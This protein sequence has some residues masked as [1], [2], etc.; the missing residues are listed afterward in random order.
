MET[1]MDNEQKPKPRKG[2]V[3]GGRAPGQRN[4]MPPLEKSARATLQAMLGFD[5]AAVAATGQINGRGVAARQRLFETLHGL[6]PA[7]PKEFLEALRFVWDRAIGTPTKMRDDAVQKPSVIFT[8]VHGYQPWSPLAPANREMDARSAALNAAN[9]EEI[10]MRALEKAKP[11]EVL[12]AES[13]AADEG[14][15]LE[16]VK[17]LPP[18][19]PSAYR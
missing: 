13:K 3:G 19:D 10:R 5:D 17:P 8:S 11:P 7:T 4:I 6:R 1:V 12:E 16:V 15:G 18:E 2:T 9:D 14:E